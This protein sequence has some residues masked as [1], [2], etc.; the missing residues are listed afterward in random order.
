MTH[1]WLFFVVKHKT[2]HVVPKQLKRGD[3][4][5]PVYGQKEKPRGSLTYIVYRKVRRHRRRHR[6]VEHKVGVR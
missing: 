1:N 2:L 5:S 6:Q 4:A 3:V